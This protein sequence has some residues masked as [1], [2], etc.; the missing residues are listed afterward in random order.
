MAEIAEEG[1]ELAELGGGLVEI[2]HRM[3]LEGGVDMGTAVV[4]ERGSA[5]WVA[6]RA[7]AAVGGWLP[8][9]GAE[10]G[11]DSLLVF[12]G[13]REWMEYFHLHNRRAPAAARGGSYATAMTLGAA[14][15]LARLLRA[16]GA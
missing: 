14:A 7:E 10:I 16:P 9:E 1:V 12:V 6:G 15:E 2:R 5:D 8:E 3:V 13:G 4:I 11:G